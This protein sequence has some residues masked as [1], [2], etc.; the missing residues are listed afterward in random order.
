MKQESR[1]LPVDKF[2]NDWGVKLVT[3]PQWIRRGK[4]RTERKIGRDWSIPELPDKPERG[5]RIAR[6][7]IEQSDALI[8]SEYPL[9]S[10]CNTIV[11][12]QDEIDKRSFSV[13]FI[14]SQTNLSESMRLNRKEVES[15]EYALIS[16]GRTSQGPRIQLI[17]WFERRQGE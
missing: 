15:L 6:Y 13:E 12:C 2:S 17:P 11:I 8:V 4:L 5:F 7:T 14:N 3:V 9:V 1:F 16:S 10:A